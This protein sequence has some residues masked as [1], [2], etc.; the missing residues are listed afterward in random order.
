[1]K[2]AIVVARFNDFVT[3]RLLTGAREALSEAGLGPESVEVHHVPGAFEI[4]LAAEAVAARVAVEPEPKGRITARLIADEQGVQVIV[5]DN[6]VGLPDKDRDRLTEPYVTTREKGTGLGLA[7]VK[8]ILGDHGGELILTDATGGRGA[9]A[10][11]K[12]PT[13]APGASDAAAG[14]EPRAQDAGVM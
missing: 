6:G 12:L 10:V 1:M 11:L 13:A 7:I 14:P 9:R 4:P 3:E 5:E 2:V 8:R